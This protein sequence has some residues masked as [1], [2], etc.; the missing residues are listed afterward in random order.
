[1]AALYNTF[2]SIAKAREA[3]NRHEL[4]DGKSY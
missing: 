1:M 3:T 2:A 4:D